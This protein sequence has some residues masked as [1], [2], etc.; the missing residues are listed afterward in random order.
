MGQTE[1]R[2]VASLRNR[3]VI[4][5]ISK[6]SRLESKFRQ[7]DTLKSVSFCLGSAAMGGSTCL[8]QLL[9]RN[10]SA[11]RRRRLKIFQ[12]GI[13]KSRPLLYYHGWQK[14]SCC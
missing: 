5:D 4:W 9:G 7:K 2:R 13:D 14:V 6:I 11:L 8:F 12:S 1:E 10:G 3:E